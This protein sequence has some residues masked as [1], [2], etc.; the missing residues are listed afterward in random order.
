MVYDL[1]EI[2]ALPNRIIMPFLSKTNVI[3]IIGILQSKQAHV[4]LKG[5]EK[6]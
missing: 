3:Y 5:T 4:L 1:I 6:L 2:S